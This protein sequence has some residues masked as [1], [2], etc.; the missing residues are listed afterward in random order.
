[1]ADSSAPVPGK[2]RVIHVDDEPD[3]L[4][5]TRSQ[6]EDADPGLEVVSVSTP[7]EALDLLAGHDLVLTDYQMP[8]MD[9]IEFA[10]RVKKVKDL[11]VILYTGRGSE[12]VAS[13]A[14]SAGISDYL[15]KEMDPGHYQV[16]ARRIRHAVESRRIERSLRESDER[17]RH[18]LDANMDAVYVITDGRF[19]YMNRV[20]AE[21]IGY[22]P[23]EL[24]GKPIVDVVTPEQRESVSRYAASRASGGKPPNRYKISLLKKGGGI[25]EVETHASFIE[26]EGKPSTL[27]V[28]R[29]VT[30]ME[31]AA[32]ALR[33]S[34]S[35]KT[36]LLATIPDGLSR[37]DRGYR[38]LWINEV[39]AARVGK[40]PSEIIGKP[41]Y[42][43]FSDRSSP[44]PGCHVSTVFE[45]GKPRAWGTTDSRGR[46]MRITANPIREGG[47][48]ASVIV[49]SRDV[50]DVQRSQT[51][52][53][54]IHSSTLKLDASQTHDEVWGVVYN[55]LTEVLGYKQTGIGVVERGK[56]AFKA[57]YR[58]AGRDNLLP[59][60]GRGVT[61]RALR[62][63][64]TQLVD[65][66]LSDPDYVTA[67]P[68]DPS[69]VFRSE[70]AV[71]VVVEGR[72]I[73]VLNAESPA[74]GE[75][76]EDDRKLLEL[77]ALYASQAILRIRQV[78]LLRESEEKYRRLAENAADVLFVIAMD[79]TIKYTSRE[80]NPH[81]GFSRGEI[82]GENISRF[83]KPSDAE[84][85]MRLIARSIDPSEVWTP[86][87]IDVA[88]KGGG[89]AV[90]ELNSSP[91]VEGG[92]VTEIQV[93][94]REV[95]TRIN[96]QRKL[97][98]LHASAH[99]LSEVQSLKGVWEIAVET[100]R[101][102]LGFMRAEIGV[103][104]GSSVV[105]QDG[106]EDGAPP[107]VLSL[108]GRSVT[109][110][111]IETRSTQIIRDVSAE[112]SYV[113]WVDEA[114]HA[115]ELVVPIL[116]EGEAV[117]VINLE[118]ERLDAFAEEEIHLAE[119]LAIHIASAV[120]RLRHA[121]AEQKERERLSA[122][123]ESSVH[124]SAA[125][126]LD[127]VW[128]LVYKDLHTVMGFDMTGVGFVDGGF[129]RWTSDTS[130]LPKGSYQLP[131]DGPGI[132]VRA[133]RT[134]KTQLVTDVRLDPDYVPGPRE[135][136]DPPYLSELAVPVIVEGK[137]IAVLNVEVNVE[138][139]LNEADARLLETLAL[140][141]ATAVT[142]IRQQEAERRYGHRLE[143]LN[144]HASALEEVEDFQAAMRLTYDSLVSLGLHNPSIS[145]IEGGNLCVQ[146]IADRDGIV[147]ITL[148]LDGP[149]IT[150]RAA[151]T[152]QTQLVN[153][154]ASDPDL[155][156]DPVGLKIGSELVVPIKKGEKVIGVLNLESPV[157][158][159]YT[160]DDAR[161]AEMLVVH[162]SS[163]IT[164][165]G[166]L[167]GL[168]RQVEERTSA[169]LAAEKLAAAGRVSAMVAHDLRGPLQT[170]SN[171]SRVIRLKP[172]RGDEMLGYIDSAV[173]RS[174][175][176]IE[177]LRHN[178]REEPTRLALTDLQEVVSQ[179]IKELP[180]ATDITF[181]TSMSG[182]LSSVPVDPLK[183]RR[184]LDNLLRNAVEAMPGGG[185]IAVRV[186]RLEGEVVFS[187]SD[188]GGGIPPEVAGSLFK[189]FA[190]TKPGG[191]GLGLSYCSKAV[192]EHGGSISVSSAAGRGTIFTVRL[193]APQCMPSIK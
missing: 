50:T 159:A 132:S 85:I 165:L 126:T 116:V 45:T 30:E 101:S 146:D 78:D 79:G 70:L 103:V 49:L 127:E 120:D 192:E 114:R 51:R 140:H 186:E 59:L 109:L 134:G 144:R 172:E 164:R 115:S 106:G 187:V 117:A 43:V 112:P 29:D 77:L 94:V 179:A 97:S 62:T 34:E 40:K 185:S 148:P 96:F 19:T 55:A 13:A 166:M 168:H 111:A 84:R 157:E 110:R 33:R 189:P 6:L 8:D 174:I 124:L 193:P 118:E 175:K 82:V 35:E 91:I 54:A 46:I 129:V 131:F 53:N 156:P 1:M 119:T 143:I 100:L 147:P 99:R 93:V 190:T 27:S 170:I 104:S 161:I 160:E 142:R 74:I 150:V 47:A 65:D 83:L 95:S 14:F 107:F 56:L 123:H 89:T 5:F 23:E 80:I 9:G 191:L 136:G 11:P 154:A 145:L 133:A 32:E 61:L 173:E 177:D 178:T 68:D 38:Y 67:S 181:E 141:A 24:I 25:V 121:E 31:R 130:S 73:A 171:A 153:D 86:I 7:F 108:Q 58:A 98:S 3:Q 92:V 139:A 76:D 15:R 17:Y 41:C 102:V 105:F 64:Q 167:E 75:F 42:T 176:M 36:T 37:V 57:A 122:L 125:S 21:I 20:G 12:E 155:V 18:L 71:P 138:G 158:G 4:L 162:V 90:L 72:G 169:L 151:R 149:G 137:A 182:D 10:R 163:T 87:V 44:C 88:K 81:I 28:S 63:L 22:T 183:F 16:L 188:T 184:V 113:P 180:T 66:T 52:T 2:I 152:G 39:E 135:E 128:R 26:Y 69:K 48:V 60:D